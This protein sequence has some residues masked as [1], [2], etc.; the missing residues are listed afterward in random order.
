MRKTEILRQ[1]AD[2][3]NET[4]LERLAGQMETLRQTE[5]QNA[6][7]LAAT[8]EPLAQAMAA[9]TDETRQTLTEIDSKSMEQRGGRSEE[10]S[11]QPEPSRSTNGVEALRFGSPNRRGD[12]SAHTYI[13]SEKMNA[14]QILTAPGG[15]YALSAPLQ[16]MICLTGDGT[17]YV[18]ASHEKDHHVLSFIER[19]TRHAHP[20]RVEKVSLTQIKQ[21]YDTA[22]TGAAPML[23][24]A[25]SEGS[26]HRQTEVV[27]LIRE[28]VEKGA[29]DVH[30]IVDPRICAVRF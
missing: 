13:G 12:C 1:S 11:R 15:P 30:F 18:S 10:S 14:V 21:L 22:Q 19:L 7:A 27:R 9:L 25:S 29:S 17:L 8:L 26:T 16:D 4:R 24:T 3:L 6:Q 20:F 23:R 2:S 28:A 5:H